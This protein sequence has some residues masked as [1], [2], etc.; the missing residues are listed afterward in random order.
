[1]TCFPVGQLLEPTGRFEITAQNEHQTC[2]HGSVRCYFTLGDYIK[3]RQLK[4]TAQSLG[5][6][7]P[8]DVIS[9]ASVVKA[10][11]DIVIE[12]IAMRFN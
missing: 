12:A 9:I 7:H 10:V 6:S 2:F 1:M 11:D 3:P 5:L 4:N 8:N